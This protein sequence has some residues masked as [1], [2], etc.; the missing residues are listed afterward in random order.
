MKQM[1]L[2]LLAAAMLTF[3]AFADELELIENE[4]EIRITLRGRPVIAYVKQPRPLPTGIE[5]HFRRSGYIHPVYTPT[6][7][8]ITGDYP[9]DHAHQHAL[10]FAWTKSTFD[11]KKSD[12][13]NQAQQLG[14]VEFRD[15]IKIDRH[16]SRVSFSA[17]HAFTV[18][19]GKKKVDVLDEVWTVTVHLTPEDHFLFDLESSQQCAGE[20]PLILEKYHYG[21]M[22]FRGPSSW[23][24]EKNDRSPQPGG[25][26]FLTSDGKD[27]WE[28]NHTR[29][30][31]VSMSGKLDGRDAS[32]TA[33]G[34]P[35][36]FRWP[37]HVRLHP[38]KPYFCFAPMVPGKFSIQPGQKYVS[39]YRFLVTSGPTDP[40][41]I[42]RHWRQYTGKKE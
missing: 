6:G 41:R 12:F 9:R 25:I 39:K 8:P 16:K 11:G 30:N 26:K 3:P 10:F 32:L 20:K 23:L 2:V 38:S 42:N 24:R 22:A 27:R 4:K 37:Q 36:N 35:Q 7:Q 17:R 28:G 29:P 31:W 19:K 40:E 18:G 15:I 34:S 1:K 21:G 5:E 14:G 13:W 33:F